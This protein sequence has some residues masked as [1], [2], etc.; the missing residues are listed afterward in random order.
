M[1]TL[2][3]T[4]F[5][6]EI[7]RRKLGLA[8]DESAGAVDALRNKGGSRTPAKRA[9][10]ERARDRARRAGVRPQRSYT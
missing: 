9:I 4:G 1:R 2:T 10:I 8:M 5:L 7:E 6:A 3:L